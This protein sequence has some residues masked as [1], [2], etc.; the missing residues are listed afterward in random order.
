MISLVLFMIL[1]SIPNF[2]FAEDWKKKYPNLTIEAGERARATLD[3]A[4]SS[5]RYSEFNDL[6]F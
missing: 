4:S 6:S 3:N 5:S 1:F 2:S